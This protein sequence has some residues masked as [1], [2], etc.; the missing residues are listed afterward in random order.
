VKDCRWGLSIVIAA[1]WTACFPM[2]VAAAALLLSRRWPGAMSR[3]SR[4]LAVA[5]GDVLLGIMAAGWGHRPGPVA[6]T[7]RWLPHA[8]V[9][10]DFYAIPLAIGVALAYPRGRPVAKAARVLGLL[11][12]LGAILLASFTGYVGPSNEQINPMTLRRF[13]VLHYWVLP[14][15]VI[16]LVIWWYRGLRPDHGTLSLDVNETR[17]DN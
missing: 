7:H 1:V 3:A 14:S 17:A 9:I 6:A 15:V 12:V 16:V 8:L 2:I 10:L 13:Q 11:A 4:C 5:S